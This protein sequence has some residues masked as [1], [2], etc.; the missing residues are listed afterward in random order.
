MGDIYLAGYKLIGKITCTQGG[1]KLTNQILR[2]VF[3]DKKNFS[4]IEIKEKNL[5]YTLIN[6]NVLKSIA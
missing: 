5:P 3:S 6:R 1:H 2:K 4:I